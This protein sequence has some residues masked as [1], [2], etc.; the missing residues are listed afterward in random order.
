M[1]KVMAKIVLLGD[2]AVGKT[3]IRKR[4]LG[5]GFRESH[6]MTI[7]ADFSTKDI[8]IDN[9]RTISAQIWDLAGQSQFAPVRK[10]FYQ[11]TQGAFLVFDVTNQQSFLNLNLWIR[12][13]WIN[14][15]AKKVPII[16]IGNKIDLKNERKV[17][18]NEG[19]KYRDFLL[20]KPELKGIDAAYIETS[21]K[22]GTN[23]EDAF[24]NMSR[25]VYESVM[26]TSK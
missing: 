26:E 10:R 17:T 14:N 11:G 16:I 1:S 4:Y 22:D 19:N 2:G 5:L 21:A 3:S 13:L 20:N 25:I 15:N 7:G 6:M 23:I 24:Q 18:N 9:D 8:K 12:E